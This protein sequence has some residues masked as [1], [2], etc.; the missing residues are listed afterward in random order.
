LA[1][2]T[3][4]RT[5]GGAASDICGE[6]WWQAYQRAGKARV[7]GTERLILGCAPCMLHDVGCMVYGVGFMDQVL[8]F[9]V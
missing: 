2:S 3:L 5:W 4:G 8:G 7:E 1:R 9:R 6:A